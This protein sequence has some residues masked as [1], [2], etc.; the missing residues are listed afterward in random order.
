MFESLFKKNRL[1]IE[2]VILKFFLQAVVPQKIVVKVSKIW[3]SF[4]KVLTATC[5]GTTHF[6]NTEY[7]SK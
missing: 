3:R 1:F 2:Y 6:I 7:C 4:G 5:Y